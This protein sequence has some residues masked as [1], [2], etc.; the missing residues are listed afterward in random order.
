MKKDLIINENT[1][2]YKIKHFKP[3]KNY[4]L[5]LVSPRNFAFTMGLYRLKDLKMFYPANANDIRDGFNFL[6]NR[7]LEG[8]AEIKK[9]SKYVQLLSF[10]NERSD[11]PYILILPG[12]G[13][14]DVAAMIEGFP[15][16]N[17]L[18]N[19]GYLAYIVLIKKL[20]ILNH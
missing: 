19:L 16:A 15:V 2:I 11:K 18:Y 9:F 6:K 3:L 14:H 5:A 17:Y 20:F 10:K 12:G 1:R 13:Y 7:V 8:N 4:K